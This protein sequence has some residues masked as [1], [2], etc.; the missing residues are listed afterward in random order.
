MPCGLKI[1]LQKTTNKHSFAL[2]HKDYAT[3]GIYPEPVALHGMLWGTNLHDRCFLGPSRE[4]C[5][6]TPSLTAGQSS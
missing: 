5:S 2:T 1:T 3:G 4:G 6:G